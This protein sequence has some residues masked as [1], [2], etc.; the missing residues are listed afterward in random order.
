MS[1]PRTRLMTIPKEYRPLVKMALK[2]GWKLEF[3]RHGHP[4][5]TS[6]DGE[7]S[8][9]IPSSSSSPAMYTAIKVRLA[10]AGLTL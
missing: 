1:R 10:K 7:F 8:T 3:S 5:L 2:E 9:P 6:P 4:K